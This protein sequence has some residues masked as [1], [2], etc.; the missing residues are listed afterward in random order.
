MPNADPTQL[1][2]PSTASG[3]GGGGEEETA[4]ASSSASHFAPSASLSL[5]HSG[6]QIGIGRHSIAPI[7]LQQQQQQQIG[8]NA[9]QSVAQWRQTIGGIGGG[10]Q[11]E[12]AQRGEAVDLAK[13]YR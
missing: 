4:A 3:G 6:K 5:I 9:L 8:A 7:S 11:P 10:G 13:V 12:M 2:G 1:E